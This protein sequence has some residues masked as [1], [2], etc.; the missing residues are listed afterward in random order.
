MLVWTLRVTR[1]GFYSNRKP[2]PGL[3]MSGRGG[4]S[5]L[6]CV[7]DVEVTCDETEHGWPEV[8][9][10]GSDR[11]AATRRV[12]PGMCGSSLQLTRG[13]VGILQLIGGT[14]GQCGT[15]EP[16]HMTC[17]APSERQVRATLWENYR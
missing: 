16:Q 13:A 3:R 10:W 9:H 17:H 2:P 15:P 7:D 5:R 1:T 6:Q 8:V 14:A 11:G 12:G 4:T